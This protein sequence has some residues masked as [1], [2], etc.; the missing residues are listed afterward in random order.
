[1]MT[2]SIAR[3]VNDILG[4]LHCSSDF[5]VKCFIS[6]PVC[7]YEHIV[8]TIYTYLYWKYKEKS[9]SKQKVINFRISADTKQKAKKL[10]EAD[11]RSLSNWITWLI[12]R[13][14]RKSKKKS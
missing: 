6:L 10:A 14:I 11:G 1:M 2:A 3:E 13:E 4:G 12:E 7:I 5:A 9:M 8:Y